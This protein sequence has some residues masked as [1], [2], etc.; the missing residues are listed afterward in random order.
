MARSSSLTP[1]PSSRSA[2]ETRELSLKGNQGTRSHC[3]NRKI[4]AEDLIRSA[5]EKNFRIGRG[6]GACTLF[7]VL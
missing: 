1:A 2:K 7:V 4:V 6:N 5:N 3:V